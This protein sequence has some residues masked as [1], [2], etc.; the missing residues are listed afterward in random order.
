MVARDAKKLGFHCRGLSHSDSMPV[1]RKLNKEK[2]MC[3][4]TE[5]KELNAKANAKLKE[6]IAGLKEGTASQVKSVEKSICSDEQAPTKLNK[7]GGFKITTDASKAKI[8]AA[9][10]RRENDIN[11]DESRKAQVA[12]VKSSP[13]TKAL[14][15][16]E[17]TRGEN[18]G[19]WS[20][21]LKG[22]VGK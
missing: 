7:E 5:A 18:K 21:V 22:V 15:L 4:F 6:A 13:R 14:T 2:A 11:T 1:A 3:K 8:K 19:Q 9:H 16:R 10:V 17:E 20:Y 12:M